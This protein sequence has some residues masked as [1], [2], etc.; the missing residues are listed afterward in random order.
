MLGE[1]RNIHQENFSFLEK[2]AVFWLPIT[3]QFF[4]K[5]KK[6]KKSLLF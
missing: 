1:R 5:N 4:F 2:H 6:D 3:K